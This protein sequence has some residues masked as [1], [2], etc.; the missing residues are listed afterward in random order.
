MTASAAY[1]SPASGTVNGSAGYR[2]TCIIFT[3]SSKQPSAVIAIKTCQRTTP[4]VTKRAVSNLVHQF[5]KL[6]MLRFD[7]CTPD[8]EQLHRLDE[9]NTQLF[10]LCTTDP[11][12]C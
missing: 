10:D 11:Q 5:I 9:D 4:E 12:D 2:N 6:I 8:A 1:I 7:R 3:Y